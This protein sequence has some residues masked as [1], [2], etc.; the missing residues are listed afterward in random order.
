MVPFGWETTLL[1]SGGVPVCCVM[2]PHQE[3][4]CSAHT[5]YTIILPIL[6]HWTFLDAKMVLPH[7]LMMATSLLQQ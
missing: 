1:C 5:G 7:I 6:P 2:F 4:G 3:S